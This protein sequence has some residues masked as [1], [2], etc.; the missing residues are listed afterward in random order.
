MHRLLPCVWIVLIAVSGCARPVEEAIGETVLGPVLGIAAPTLHGVWDV[1]FFDEAG[2]EMARV[3]M[4]A[5][6][7]GEMPFGLAEHFTRDLP[8]VPIPGLDIYLDMP[9]L[10]VESKPAGSFDPMIDFW[11]FGTSVRGSVLSFFS[12]SD[13]MV[14]SGGTVALTGGLSFDGNDSFTMGELVFSFMGYSMGYDESGF[15]RLNCNY[16][17]GCGDLIRKPLTAVAHRVEES[18]PEQQAVLDETGIQML[19]DRFEQ[20]FPD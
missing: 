8:E 2:A 15:Q 4:Y 20:E 19:L 13:R 11:S 14:G 3:K 16:G 7:D 18:L 5:W 9:I 12:D 1:T 10:F 17:S 6:Q